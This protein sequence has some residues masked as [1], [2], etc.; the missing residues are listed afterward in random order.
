MYYFNC[1]NGIVD[2]LSTGLTKNE[3]DMTLLYVKSQNYNV[4]QYSMTSFVSPYFVYWTPNF[5]IFRYFLR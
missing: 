3:R 2:I 1:V 5:K 4:I